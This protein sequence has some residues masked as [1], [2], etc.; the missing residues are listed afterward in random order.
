MELSKH[1]NVSKEVFDRIVTEQYRMSLFVGET[2]SHD[3][4]LRSLISRADEGM[5]VYGTFELEYA[6]GG[7]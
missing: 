5:V 4:V 3:E 7:R 6:G 1:I 2:P